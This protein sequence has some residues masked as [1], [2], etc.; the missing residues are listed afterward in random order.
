MDPVKLN[1]R[2]AAIE[3]SAIRTGKITKEMIERKNRLLEILKT[4]KGRRDF[5]YARTHIKLQPFFKRFV[6]DKHEATV[7]K[8]PDNIQTTFLLTPFHFIKSGEDWLFTISPRLAIALLPSGNF[9]DSSVKDG[10]WKV[11]SEETME[12][13]LE[14]A[15][16]MA[17]HC[18]D[19]H[20]IGERYTLEKVKTLI[21][22]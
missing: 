15:I 22:G 14:S 13:L 16:Q 6:M 21:G 19:Q 10:I 17:I 12:I 9:N 4:Q 2:I 8:V 3:V 20:L 5:Y 11:D 1:E 7:I 18:N